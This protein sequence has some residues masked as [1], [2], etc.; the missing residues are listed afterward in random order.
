VWWQQWHASGLQFPDARCMVGRGCGGKSSF[1]AGVRN[2]QPSACGR[3]ALLEGSM[4]GVARLLRWH[5]EQ[6]R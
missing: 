2:R 4:G 6:R 3:V 5:N 1:G